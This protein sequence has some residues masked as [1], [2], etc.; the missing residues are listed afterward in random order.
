MLT[1]SDRSKLIFGSSAEVM[2]RAKAGS[3]MDYLDPEIRRQVSAS[4]QNSSTCA[5]LISFRQTLGAPS[6]YPS[7]QVLTAA[8]STLFPF[9]EVLSPFTTLSVPRSSRASAAHFAALSR[10][11]TGSRLAALFAKQ[12]A[13]S[14]QQGDSDLPPVVQAPEGILDSI[15]SS[16]ESS[17]PSA[18]ARSSS[19]NLELRILAVAKAVQRP[20][21]SAAIA[22][23]LKLYIQQ[24]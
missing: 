12:P 20:A 23:S 15:S 4:T 8:D 6:V 10:Q 24:H 17:D 18:S 13:A 7:S 1:N 16:Q 19:R 22:K 5:D 2:L 14:P 11:S 9:N 21:V 3:S